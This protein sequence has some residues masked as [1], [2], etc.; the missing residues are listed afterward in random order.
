MA[1][2]KKYRD[3]WKLS[4]ST[5]HKA[6]AKDRKGDFYVENEDGLY[7]VFGTE[8][9]FCYSLSSDRKSANKFASGMRMHRKLRDKLVSKTKRSR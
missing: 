7:G 2:K 6:Y 8:S 3:P 5:W 4:S 1:S 9:G